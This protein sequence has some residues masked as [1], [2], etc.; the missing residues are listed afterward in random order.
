MLIPCLARVY[1]KRPSSVPVVIIVRNLFARLTFAFAFPIAAAV[2]ELGVISSGS[3]DA[4]KA[5]R[6]P[7]MYSRQ[8]N[9]W[10]YAYSIAS[11]LSELTQECG[12]GILA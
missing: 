10:K 8:A 6:Q 7:S 9:L 1:E 2:A 3:V 12:P 11:F 4:R 5:I